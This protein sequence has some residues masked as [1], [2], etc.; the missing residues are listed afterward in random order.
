MTKRRRRNC[1][2]TRPNPRPKGAYPLPNGD[3]VVVGPCGPHDK[4]GRSIR[5]R[6][7]HRA[8][9]NARFVAQA[10]LDIVASQEPNR[11]SADQ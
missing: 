7:V 3:Y 5:I 10:L 9:P 11:E 6:A 1:R 8:E 2:D 4:R